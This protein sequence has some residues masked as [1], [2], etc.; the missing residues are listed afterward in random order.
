MAKKLYVGNLPYGFTDTDLQNL[1]TAHGTVQSAQVIMDRDTGRSKGFGFV[2]ISDGTEA[3]AAINALKSTRPVPGKT[4]AA[5][6]AAIPVAAAVAAAA[7]AIARVIN[8][9]GKHRTPPRPL[10]RGGVLCFWPHSAKKK[11]PRARPNLSPNQMKRNARPLVI[12]Q[13]A[14]PD[15]RGWCRKMTRRRDR[16]A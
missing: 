10:G 2:E 4:V 13:C 7:T 8:R 12:L 1:F 16:P 9:C 3:D 5:A 14:L 6:S 11:R 15:T